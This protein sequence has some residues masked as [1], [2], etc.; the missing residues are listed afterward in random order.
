[1]SKD[2]EGKKDGG[3]EKKDDHH[4]HGSKTTLGQKL[5]AVL[6]GA[7]MIGVFLYVLGP[8]VGVG[9]GGL[10]G[11]LSTVGFGAQNVANSAQV[12]HI[13]LKAVMIRF[14][15]IGFDVVALVGLGALLGLILKKIKDLVSPSG[16]ADHH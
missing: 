12:T 14:G 11:L 6:L 7:L 15:E 2:G 8:L 1:M 3:A 13:G 5:G 10:S 16:G 9:L 4:D